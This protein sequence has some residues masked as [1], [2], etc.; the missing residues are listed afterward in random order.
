M[1]W[2]GAPGTGHL[3]MGSGM[4]AVI[5]V[6]SANVLMM[7]SLMMSSGFSVT[8]AANVAGSAAAIVGRPEFYAQCSFRGVDYLMPIYRKV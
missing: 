8:T 2:S 7:S 4:V 3:I 1:A 5:D 6:V